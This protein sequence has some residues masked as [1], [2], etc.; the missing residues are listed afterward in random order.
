[1]FIVFLKLTD[2]R[3]QA[4]ALMDGHNAWL[5]QGFEDGVFRLAGSLSP[6]PGGAVIA[7]GLSRHQIEDRVSTDPFVIE[8]V[9]IPEIFE[10]TPGRL[11]PRLDFLQNPA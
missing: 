8:G 5:R 9:A 1:M 6:G 11:D 4:A 3:D 2:R 7:S 10:V